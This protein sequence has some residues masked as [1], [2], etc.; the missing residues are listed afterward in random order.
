MT[1]Q[2]LSHEHSFLKRALCWAFGH[3]LIFLPYTSN[4]VQSVYRCD[5]C[6]ARWSG[7]VWHEQF[8]GGY[9]HL[10]N[11]APRNPAERWAD[12]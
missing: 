8:N 12:A 9:G 11:R 3:P 1:A 6:R 4:I 10:W 7:D 2:S 5:R